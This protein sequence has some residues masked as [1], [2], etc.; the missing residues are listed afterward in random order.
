MCPNFTG[1]KTLTVTWKAFWFGLVPRFFSEGFSL[2]LVPIAC[3]ASPGN[4]S[5][6]SLRVT[7]AGLG[8]HHIPTLLPVPH[9]PCHLT[10]GPAWGK[11]WAVSSLFMWSSATWS[12]N[13]PQ[14]ILHHTFL[15][16]RPPHLPTGFC[17][18]AFQSNHLNPLTCPW[19]KDLGSSR[20]FFNK[21]TIWQMLELKKASEGVAAY[22]L[23]RAENLMT[24]LTGN[25]WFLSLD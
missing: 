3:C 8:A 2:K 7:L 13:C 16:C 19:G 1:R 6:V 15:P 14:A 12:P 5:A 22:V 21:Y 18:I 20:S 10:H 11:P 25:Q 4:H 24:F 9:D 23:L 17:G